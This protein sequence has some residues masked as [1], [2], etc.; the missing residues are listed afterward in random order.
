MLKSAKF[1]RQREAFRRNET[2]NR[3]KDTHCEKET[4]HLNASGKKK[5]RESPILARHATERNENFIYIL[6]RSNY[7]LF[8]PVLL[9]GSIAGFA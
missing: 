4:F 8:N 3:K 2:E 7:C 9:D 1:S 5:R 6:M